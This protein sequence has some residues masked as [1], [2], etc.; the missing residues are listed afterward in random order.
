M[1]S[2]SSCSI[3][4]RKREGAK[5]ENSRWV[6]L[7]SHS[8]TRQHGVSATTAASFSG[9][10]QGCS[11]GD[12]ATETRISISSPIVRVFLRSLTAGSDQTSGPRLAAAHI[13]VAAIAGGPVAAHIAV[14]AIAGRCHLSSPPVQHRRRREKPQLLLSS[15]TEENPDDPSQSITLRPSLHDRRRRCSVAV[16]TASQS[17]YLPVVAAEEEESDWA[18]A[19][20]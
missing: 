14:A 2:S 16:V 7:L 15:G 1:G 9:D 5:W 13:A 20:L 18:T 4:G 8:T 11:G 17:G 3:S 12:N 6:L 10:G 19:L